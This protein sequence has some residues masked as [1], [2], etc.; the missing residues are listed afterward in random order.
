MTGTTTHERALTL[1]Q[2]PDAVRRFYRGDTVSEIADYFGVSRGALAGVFDRGGVVRNVTRERVCSAFDAETSAAFKAAVQ[3]GREVEAAGAELGKGARASRAHARVLGLIEPP[4][5]KAVVSFSRDMSEQSA[6]HA[7]AQH[8][9]GDERLVAALLAGGGF[10]RYDDECDW[11]LDMHGQR[12]A[13]V[14]GKAKD[15][16]AA[17]RAQLAAQV[18]A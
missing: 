4:P 5:A 1:V 6:A 2:I 16:L 9:A 17:A 15:I 18:A 12:K 10:D 13:A 3:A 7:L 14:S 11:L 8:E